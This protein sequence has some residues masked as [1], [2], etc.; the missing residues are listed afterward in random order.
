MMTRDN[1]SSFTRLS[2]TP[3]RLLLALVG[4]SALV[5]MGIT[6]SPLERGYA[7]TQRQ[8]RG[9]VALYVAEVEQMQ[10][11]ASYYEAASQELRARGYPTRNV[12]NWR[13]PL[14][15]GLIGSLPEPR[16]GQALL[17]CLGFALMLAAFEL[18][19]REAG[20]RTALLGAALLT[21]P[22][23]FCILGDIYCM[24]EIWAGVL[25]ALSVCL[26]GI[27]RWQLGFASGLAALFF[28]ELAAPY[29]ALCF[30]L[31]F[32]ARRWREVAAWLVGG[33]AYAAFYAWHLLQVLPRIGPEDLAH[34][35]GWLQFG[36]A[37]QVIALAQVNAY[38]LL[39]PQAA[40]ACLLAAAL[41]GFASWS[42]PAGTR[43]GLTAT[44]FV[45]AF[46]L[47]GH[48]FN[49]YWGAMFGPL[50]CLGAALCPRA[51]VDLANAARSRQ[52]MAAA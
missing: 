23:M 14:P 37:A 52:L 50:L 16:I 30:V 3:A 38:L 43:A 25:V 42:T 26:Y 36:G 45:V 22:L 7:G 6:L 29:V 8:G 21:G 5:L 32:Q 34:H 12:F 27:D 1:P 18:L 24:P 35:A 19:A 31:A 44:L 39:L 10:R 11:G 2:P 48:E 47:V 51:C 46:A 28:R 41:L 9:D 49:Q 4:L 33:L 20:V 13:S 40:A 17:A 15:I